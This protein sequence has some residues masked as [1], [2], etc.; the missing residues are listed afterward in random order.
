[1]RK[2]LST[3]L[4][5]PLFLLILVALNPQIAFAQN[6][7]ILFELS[8]SASSSPPP[9]SNPLTQ[10]ADDAFSFSVT[11]PQSR[12][13]FSGSASLGHF[14]GSYDSGVS[15]HPTDIQS[16]SAGS[17][18][19]VYIKYGSGV[20]Y[21]ATRRDVGSLSVSRSDTSSTY[22]GSSWSN[23]IAQSYGG[24][25]TI[26]TTVN[27]TYTAEGAVSGGGGL[28]TFAAYPGDYYA[29]ITLGTSAAANKGSGWTQVDPVTATATADGTV[30]M[31]IDVARFPARKLTPGH[32]P[33]SDTQ[34]TACASCP[35]GFGNST[36]E[37]VSQSETNIISGNQTVTIYSS[38]QTGK[39]PVLT[40]IT[41]NSQPRET[42]RPMGNATFSW[43]M[44][45]VPSISVPGDTKVHR[46]LVDGDGSWYDTGRSNQAPT[47]PAGVYSSLATI[48][49]GYRLSNAGPPGDLKKSGNFTYDFDSSGK[50]TQIKDP[51]GNTQTIAYS[52][53]SIIL[54][55]TNTGRTVN[56]TL[57]GGL[58]SSISYNGELTQYLTY[59]SGKLAS[60]RMEK[61]TGTVLR[62]YDFTYDG[63]GRLSTFTQDNDS[64]S[65]QTFSY[66]MTAGNIP[67]ANWSTNE[68]SSNITYDVSSYRNGMGRVKVGNDKGGYVLYDYDSKFRV[69]RVTLPTHN[70]GTANVVYD[71]VYDSNYNLTQA[72]GG[73]T[74]LTFAYNAKGNLT[75]VTDSSGAYEA[76]TY[77]ANNINPLTYAD[78][79]GTYATLT[80]GTGSGA[81]LVAT[82]TD[83]LSHTWNYT[84][85]GIGQP[86]VITQPTSS[87]ESATNL[88]YYGAGSKYR[89]LNT[90]TDGGSN[91][92]S[93]DD[94][95]L[96][97]T[98]T[99][100]T[101]T[102]N[103][104][105]S[106]TEFSYDGL[107]R[108][109]QVTNPDATTVQASYTGRKLDSVEDEAGTQTDFTWSAVTGALEAIAGPS[110]WGLNWE[111][112]G[113]RDL[114][115][116][117]DARSK[118]TDYQ[119]GLAAELKKVVY[120]D[121][122]QIEYKYDNQG[123]L[124]RVINARAQETELSF[125]SGSRL[126]GV[127]FDPSAEGDISI[128]RYAN[129][130]LN[131]FT[132]GLGTT[133]YEYWGDRL[134]KKVTYDYSA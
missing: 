2:V 28:Y 16:D 117:S 131:T 74:T 63:S 81:N 19:Y 57:S 48:S 107:Q 106:T 71:Y 66:T 68:A 102:A 101:T 38:T 114:T 15:N 43:D 27:E 109:T 115:E 46:I 41:L 52:S 9:A 62:R 1:M 77:Q 110:S 87:P 50:L 94:Y 95:T 49:G 118:V 67:L 98:G 7:D 127:D 126:S 79:I 111:Y 96:L 11:S 65:T 12:S 22:V 56:A 31:T 45:V 53:G 105:T 4:I 42:S 134:L 128:T 100:I 26:N 40:N 88:A 25:G 130:T 64:N 82:L 93:V 113:D 73:G 18:I 54:T 86:T 103:S 129:G 35:Y 70:G 58:I 132:D 24:I 55:D 51:E 14:E 76:I 133:S 3:A 97:G 8:G 47:M 124:N 91:V 36:D 20:E 90:V 78:N 80:Y 10:S 99:E 92:T 69:D 125:D 72:S 84:Y 121:S 33:G 21:K 123:R 61:P 120:P 104:M 44:H 108:V 23:K 13:S 60:V 116:F 122:S 17:W 34:P 119:Y 39:F 6:P 5:F 32:P 37:F 83:G 29:R 89:L 30:D 59:S 75:Q 112:D 85:N